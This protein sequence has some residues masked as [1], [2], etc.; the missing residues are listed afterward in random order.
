MYLPSNL[1]EHYT[2]MPVYLCQPD[3]T[4]IGEL[5]VFDFDGTFKFNTYSEIQFSVARTYNDVITGATFINPYYD[6]IDSIRVIY[7]RGIG[8]FIIQDVDED[9]SEVDTKT[10]SCFSLEYATASKY[11]NN[12][13]VNTGEYDSLEY[14]Y[15]MQEHGDDYSVDIAYK[16]A[17][18]FDAYE[19]YYVKEYTDTKS[20]VYTEVKIADEATF[21]DYD[22]PLFVKAFPNI[23]FYNPSTPELS[24]LHIVFNYIPEWKIGHV[25][26]DLI[27]QE[28]TFSEDRV[29]VYDFLTGTAAET[30]D[31][32]IEWDSIAGVVN[33]YATEED[34][35]TEDNYIQTRWDTDVF[36]SKQNLASQ[37]SIKYSTDDI[38]TKLKVSGGDDLA[39]RDV[40]LGQEHI[41]NLSFY[42]DPAW[43]GLDLYEKYNDYLKQTGSYTEQYTELISAWAAA[44][45]EYS[46]LMYAVPIANNVLYVGDK[47]ELLYCIY[48]PVYAEDAT[49][50]QVKD[51]IEAAVTSLQN[52]LDLYDVKEDTDANKSDNVLLTLEDKDSNSST[53]KV[54][55][56]K[57]GGA[58]AVKRTITNASSGAI[59]SQDY[60]LSMWVNKE[61][62]ASMMGLSDWTIKSI[63]TLGAYLCLVKDETKKENIE[64]YGIKLLQEKQS[65]YTKIFITQT[66]GYFSKEGSQCLASDNEPT[67]EISAGTKWLDTDSS[68][69]VVY[70]YSDGQWVKDDSVE[71]TSNYENYARFIE[72]YNKLQ[73]VQEVLVQKELEASYLL[74]GVAIKKFF[75]TPD[76]INIV[77]LTA[78]AND[79]AKTLDTEVI[80][81]GDVGDVK[82]YGVLR[83][84]MKLDPSVAYAVYVGADGYPYI[85]YYRSQGVSLAKM[86]RINKVS[87]M[88]HYFTEGELIR[89]SPFLR[90]DEYSNSNIILTGYESEEEEIKIKQ[91]L[92]EEATKEL[93]KICQPKLSFDI[94]MAN[95]MA[96]PEFAPLKEQFQLGN[97]VKVEI[98]PGYIKRARLLEVH[99][100]FDD[101]SDFSCTFGDLITTKDE[102]DK[103]ADLLQQAV[104]AGKTVAASSSSWQKA[105]EKSTALDQAIKDGLKDAALSVGSISG[106]N[107][108]WDEKG[109]LGRKLVDGTNNVYENEQFLLSNNKLLFTNDSW[110]TSKGVFGK[111]NIEDEHGRLIE[112]WGILTDA[113][114]GG[115]IQGSEIKGGT[116]E[117]GGE[118]GKFKVHS[119]GSVEI[120]D[121]SGASAYATISDFEQASGWR[122]EIVSAGSTVFTDR[123]QSATLMCKVYCKG[124][125]M[126]DTVDASNFNWYR[127]SVD[128]ASDAA[129]NAKHKGYKNINIT[130]EDVKGNASFFCEV[131]VETT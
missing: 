69:L 101:L 114:V 36:I 92:L 51:A 75:F 60:S 54:Y 124:E 3:K 81:I 91:T 70:V 111:F 8:H 16:D 120:L 6:L 94:D 29:A 33:F 79:Y 44:N 61:L 74:N 22:Q 62:T 7:V 23:R 24:L 20:Y 26:P 112:R 77:N 118:G 117:I 73:A 38:K 86:N 107:I 130:H 110:N 88:E 5:Q 52:K 104:Q 99:L 123:S 1:F 128:T 63:G 100:N 58:Y 102:V 57:T 25:D 127:T 67:G 83:F 106:Q 78:V 43:L 32:V 68:P 30:F 49:D 56:N 131:D 28:R 82:Q 39:I 95:I 89:L 21:H 126:T 71:S 119:D 13:H 53:I 14:I 96:I 121:S 18:V 59:S 9:L 42:N 11:L 17:A 47:F 87:S 122:T 72:N 116:L 129:W 109:I 41:M 50:V 90:E 125:D 80:E 76:N 93:K 2:P 48:R 35:V 84:N 85:A 37:L 97:F 98:R 55:Y 108:T 105:V 66:E 34:G 115:Y 19:R 103:T 12:F 10:V 40:N 46:D 4:I 45:N 65:V 27:F 113:M 31:Y 15:H 64:D